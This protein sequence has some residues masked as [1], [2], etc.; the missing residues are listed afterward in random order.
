MKK[1]II[2]IVA[3]MSYSVLIGI[4]SVLL[5]IALINADVDVS[6]VRIVIG[7]YVTL[8]L[9]VSYV[10]MSYVNEFVMGN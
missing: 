5:G 9:G 4:P 10:A 6:D 7:L 3:L 8:L 1:H 2:G